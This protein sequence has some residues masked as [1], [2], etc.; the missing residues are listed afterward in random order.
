MNRYLVSVTTPSYVPHTK[1]YFDTLPLIVSAE[2]RCVMLDFTPETD[3]AG[4][5]EGA[6][7]EAV[8]WVDFRHL[9][10]PASHSHF[11]VQHGAFL[12]AFNDV[13]GDDLICLTD[14]DI[15]IQRD[16]TEKEWGW[17]EQVTA[18]GRLCAY[19]NGGSGDNLQ[20]EGDRIGLAAEWSARHAPDGLDRIPCYNCGVLFGRASAFRQLQGHYERLCGEFYALA[21]HR[22]RCQLL[23]NYCVWKWMGGFQTLPEPV[24]SHAHFATPDGILLPAGS[25]VRRGVLCWQGIPVVFLHNFPDL[26][27]LT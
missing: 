8:D 13:K 19:W 16:L 26:R 3:P 5:V 15:A 20:L 2:P 14:L 10:L 27:S 25:H 11:M 24:H 21:P 17:L 6:L 12:D 9:P 23:I 18:G 22:S 1:R 7:R 4:K